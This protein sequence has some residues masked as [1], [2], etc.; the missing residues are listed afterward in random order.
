MP[1]YTFT[2]RNEQTGALVTGT[3][4][5]ASHAVLGQ[6]LLGE[7]V[8]LTSFEAKKERNHAS[9]MSFF[10]S[11]VPVLERVLFARYFALM[12]RAGLDL[13]VL[14]QHCNGRQRI[15]RFLMQF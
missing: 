3:R 15:A 7:G 4:E 8:L 2:G 1:T 14:S 6:D 5:V 11:R 13:K 12:L 10:V 9:V